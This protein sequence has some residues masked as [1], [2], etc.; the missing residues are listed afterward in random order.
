VGTV[1][2]VTVDHD[3]GDYVYV[4]VANILRERIRSGDLPPGR[5]M[6]SARTLS[7]ELEV[8]IGSVKKAIEILRDED[9]VY[10]MIG[11]GIV[12]RQA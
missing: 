8:S 12:V 7:Q 9:L 10:T 6:P 1:H 3:G 2:P 4:Q 11:R 5:V